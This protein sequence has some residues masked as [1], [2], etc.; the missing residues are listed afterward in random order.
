V[1]PAVFDGG[2]SHGSITFAPAE[3][4]AARLDDR[5]RSERTPRR[6]GHQ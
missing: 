3:R 2:S 6:T 1:S 5:V 4:F